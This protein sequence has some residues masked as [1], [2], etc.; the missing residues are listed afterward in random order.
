[1]QVDGQGMVGPPDEQ[2]EPALH[3][4][5]SG[6]GMASPMSR[7]RSKTWEHGQDE[8]CEDLVLAG[9]SIKASRLPPREVRTSP[10]R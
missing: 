5:G 10:Q 1:M 9:V 4:R 2:C 8:V 7:V 6:S 3:R